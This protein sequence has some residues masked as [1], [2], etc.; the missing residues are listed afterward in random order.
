MNDL[1]FNDIKLIDFDSLYPTKESAI[2]GL[3]KELEKYFTK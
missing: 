2:K 3:E 1:Y